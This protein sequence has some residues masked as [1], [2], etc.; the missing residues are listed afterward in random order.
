MREFR[1]DPAAYMEQRAHTLR[2]GDLDEEEARLLKQRNRRIHS[3][4]DILLRV[5]RND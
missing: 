3:V 2:S 1:A 5:F 4:V